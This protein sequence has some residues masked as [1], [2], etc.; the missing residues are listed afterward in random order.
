MRTILL[1]L[2]L[3][4]LV[5]CAGSPNPYRTDWIISQYEPS[6]GLTYVKFMNKHGL[7]HNDPK[8]YAPGRIILENGSSFGFS[9]EWGGDW[10]SPIDVK[11]FF[12]KEDRL[13]RYKAKYYDVD[14]SVK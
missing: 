2:A 6:L 10:A 14:Q 5:G 8:T 11:V 12:D 1:P 7:V 3:F 13:Y 4:G 9:R